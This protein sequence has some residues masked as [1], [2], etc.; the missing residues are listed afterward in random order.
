MMMEQL[1]AK[2]RT[3]SMMGTIREVKEKTVLLEKCRRKME[4][5]SL[6]PEDEKIYRAASERLSDQINVLCWKIGL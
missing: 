1:N 6:D 5:A 3:D 4:M 2:D